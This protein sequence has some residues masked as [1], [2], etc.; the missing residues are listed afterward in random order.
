M[1]EGGELAEGREGQD[2]H[3]C[4]TAREACMHDSKRG[5][6]PGRGRWVTAYTEWWPERGGKGHELS[7]YRS[8]T[9]KLSVIDYA[10]IS[11]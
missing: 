7:G 11:H 8:L 6:R 1:G 3:A 4:M 5:R 2:M 9:H 10:P